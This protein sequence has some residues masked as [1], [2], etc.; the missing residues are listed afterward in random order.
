M[1]TDLIEYTNVPMLCLMVGP[2]FVS[3]I[4]RST[5]ARIFSFH[6]LS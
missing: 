4:A 5:T 2:T 1:D 3:V 6:L